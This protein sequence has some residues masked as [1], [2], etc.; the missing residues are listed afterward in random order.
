M[1]VDYFKNDN[2]GFREQGFS[3]HVISALHE[4]WSK[5]QIEIFNLST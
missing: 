2:A 1:L 4:D 5:A 3:L